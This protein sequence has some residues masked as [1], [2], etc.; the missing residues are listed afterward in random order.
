MVPTTAS[1]DP[2][3]ADLIIAPPLGGR[4]ERIL[5]YVKMRMVGMKNP[6]IAAKLGI[7]HGAL[8][9][10]IFRAT[11]E[12]WLKFENPLARFEHEILPKVVDNIEYFI[13]KKDKTM[14]IEIFYHNNQMFFVL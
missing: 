13:A 9:A 10:E 8:R 11:K 2:I 12:G 5:D 14:T 6:E 7:S 3:N 4:R 1:P